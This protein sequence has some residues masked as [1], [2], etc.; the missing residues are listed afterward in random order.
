MQQFFYE[1]RKKVDNILWITWWT[2]HAIVRSKPLAATQPP[3]RH[4]PAACASV[5]ALP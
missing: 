1:T 5:A 3:P 4:R 2:S